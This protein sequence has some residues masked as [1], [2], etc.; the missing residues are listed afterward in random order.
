M[1]KP[2]WVGSA[3]RIIFGV[4]RKVFEVKGQRKTEVEAWGYVEPTRGRARWVAYR[5]GS[6]KE[7]GWASTVKEAKQEVERRIEAVP[8]KKKSERKDQSAVDLFGARS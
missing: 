6:G 5:T 1:K 3:G 7:E 2:T 4:R 8:T